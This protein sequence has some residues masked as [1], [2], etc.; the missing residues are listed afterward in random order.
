MMLGYCTCCLVNG[1]KFS[2]GQLV[3]LCNPVIP[4][5]NSRK[6]HSPWVGPY[7]I[8][9]CISD[10]VYRIQDTQ[11]PQKRIVVYCDRLKP[12]REG[13]RTQVDANNQESQAA[14][15]LKFS[16]QLDNYHLVQIFKSWMIM[17]VK[18]TSNRI[19]KQS[20]NSTAMQ[21]EQIV[22][23]KDIHNEAVIGDQQ[24]TAMTD[25]GHVLTEWGWCSTIDR[26][27]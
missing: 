5:G 3:W 22:S 6:L 8:I 21:Q 16:R 9:K 12:C 23:S 11:T 24:D 7:K 26:S 19:R 2:I 18:T 4:K 20:H 14:P 25:I 15:L 1:E 27:Y 10:T 17:K 13:M